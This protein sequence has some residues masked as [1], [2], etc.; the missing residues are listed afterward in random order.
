MI[1]LRADWVL[2]EKPKTLGSDNM[3]R[4]AEAY[5]A[6]GGVS[7]IMLLALVLM[8]AP[9]PGVAEQLPGDDWSRF[10]DA[11]IVLIGEVHDNPH[12]HNNQARAVAALKP[13][14]IVFEMLTPDLAASVTAENRTDLDALSKALQ[15]DARGW[16][17]FAMYFPI[18]SAAPEA[19][20]IGGGL[21]REDVRRATK[22]GAAAVFGDGS[23]IFGLDQ[24]YADDVQA[25]LEFEQQWAH[26]NAL[27][28][29][30]LP[31]MVEAQRLRDAAIARASLA[32]VYESRAGE[33]F[34]PVIVITGNG[35]ARSDLGV[36]ALLARLPEGFSV[37]SVGQ[38]ESEPEEPPK[39][40]YWIVTD[41]VERP[42]P[43][44]A[45]E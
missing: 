37:L 41:A 19:A 4:N 25:E 12:H 5:C 7:H 17:D 22:E 20:I 40:D 10:S 38:L 44:E 15:W 13:G 24:D 29:E 26:C 21:P 8:L 45:F 3:I 31:G 14:A 1:A 43:C 30:N 2:P 27:P 39:F 28:P 16:P 34:S 35:H 33:V 32:A 36:Q 23:E 6:V 18:F 9:L 42:D 11:D